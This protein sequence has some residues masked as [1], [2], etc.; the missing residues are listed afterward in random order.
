MKSRGDSGTALERRLLKRVE[1]LLTDVDP[2]L[3]QSPIVVAVSGGGDSL[4]LLLL[5]DRLKDA[6]KLTLHVAHLDH[7]LRGRNAQEDALFVERMAGDLGLSSTLGLEDVKS[8]RAERGLSLEEAAREVRYSFLARV[9]AGLGARGVALGH[10]ADDQAETVLMH[11]LRGSGLAGLAGMSPLSHQPSPVHEDGIVLLRPLLDVTRSETAA[12]CR[13]RGVTPREDETNRSLGFTRNRTRLELLPSLEVHNPRI[14]EALLRLSSS[15]SLDQSYILGE[16]SR[17]LGEL[18]TSD[19]SAVLIERGGFAALHPSIKRHALRLAY[20][21]VAGSPEG[22]EHSHVEA[23]VRASEAGAGRSVDLPGGLVFSVEYDSLGLRP[24]G[25]GG[26]FPKAISGE[27]PLVVPGE[28]RIPGWNV[29]AR[30]LAP[31]EGSLDTGPYSAML[32][33]ERVGDTLHVRGRRPGDRFTP[34]GMA[35]SK[36]LQDF[37]VDARIPA[38]F[39]DS[40]PL[41]VSS[42]GVVWVVGHRIA[43]WAKV[44]DGTRE[45]LALDFTPAGAAEAPSDGRLW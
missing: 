8:Y 7:G 6:L 13:W 20:Q 10:T 43:D 17:A 34:L 32:D 25:S 45:V 40:V 5:L 3:I 2:S 12:Y 37:M 29:S 11:I 24:A 9:A 33:A 36:K 31:G 39:R 4:A 44:T 18:A 15:A 35:G 23:M 30:L 27:R 19:G 14:R 1:S 28:T 41:V 21:S 22:L 26:G 38:D 16:A 42:E